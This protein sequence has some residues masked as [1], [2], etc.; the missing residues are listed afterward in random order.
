MDQLKPNGQ[1]AKNAMVILWIVLGMEIIT[2]ISNYFQYDLLHRAKNLAPI[3]S[4]EVAANDFRVK[5]V[6]VVYLIVYIICVV[7]FIQWFRR[8]YYNLHVKVPNLLFK[9]GWA[10]GSWF[11][12]IMHLYRPYQIMRELHEETIDLCDKKKVSSNGLST[13]LLGWWWFSWM[14]SSVLGRIVGQI[15][16]GAESISQL[17]NSTVAGMIHSVFNIPLTLLI[18]KIIYDYSKVEPILFDL[19]EEEEVKVETLIAE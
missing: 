8:A 13:D 9:D 19:K 18:L 11:V 4:L 3:T 5:I 14:V 2:F 10:A 6:T 16:N 1:R 7:M 15:S 17:E 12:P